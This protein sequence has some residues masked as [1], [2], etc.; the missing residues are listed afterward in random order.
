[1]ASATPAA[2]RWF[3]ADGVHL[4]TTG[5]AEFSLFLREHILAAT[6]RP[7]AAGSVYRVPVLGLAGVPAGAD[8]GEAG[9]GGVALNVTA[10]NPAGPGRLRVGD[11]GAAAPDP[12][13]VNFGAA[14]AVEPNAVVVPLRPEST[15]VCVRAKERTHVIVDVAGYF[16]AD[17]AILHP[18]A[19]RV[20][21]TRGV[22]RVSTNG[23]LPVR[24]LGQAG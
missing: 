22:A 8:A 14:G 21:D 15:E 23:V 20:I 2:D 7:V 1:E 18:A 17:P 10:V 24:V 3:A 12:S 9:V 11:C 19:G 5:N 6:A 4:T 16:A 13:S